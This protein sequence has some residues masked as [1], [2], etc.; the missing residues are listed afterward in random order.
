MKE[1]AKDES[2]RQQDSTLDLSTPPSPSKS[3]DV[4]IEND[5]ELTFNFYRE[6][7][8]SVVDTSE[9][10]KK[11]DEAKKNLIVAQEVETYL[12]EI[13][14]RRNLEFDAIEWWRKNRTRYPNVALA[15]RKWLSVTGTSTPSERVFSIC[16]IVDGTKRSS[17]LG[18]SIETQVFVHNNYEQYSSLK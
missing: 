14:G 3:V 10:V 16:G 18:E 15:A 12:M 2:I 17:L 9:D 8:I 5:D 4:P 11:M 7:E 13:D 6:N 1:L